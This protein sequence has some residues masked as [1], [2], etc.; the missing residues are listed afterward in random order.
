MATIIIDTRPQ[1][2]KLTLTVSTRTGITVDAHLQRPHLAMRWTPS[3]NS[4]QIEWK[5]TAGK[6]V[7][8]EVVGLNTL[9]MTRKFS[10]VCQWP[11][12]AE[13]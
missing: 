7:T 9:M 10:H 13:R 4:V 6:C 3:G 8:V 11:T 5:F 2:L 12:S 1:L